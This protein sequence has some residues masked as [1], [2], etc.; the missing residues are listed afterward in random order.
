MSITGVK[1]QILPLEFNKRLA[2]MYLTLESEL[3]FMVGPTWSILD[4]FEKKRIFSIAKKAY[5]CTCK[6][7][8]LEKLLR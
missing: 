5:R 6:K 7:F 1:Q 2:T 3:F 4:V 8:N